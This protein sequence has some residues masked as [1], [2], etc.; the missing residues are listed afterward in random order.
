MKLDSLLSKHDETLHEKG[1]KDSLGDSFLLKN[2]SIFYTVRLRTL[3]LGYK[4]SHNFNPE[5]LALP[6][7]QLESILVSKN[8]P[9]SDNVSAL[10]NI[11]QKT[12]KNLDWDHIVDG[13]KANYVFH[14]SCHAISRNVSDELQINTSEVKNK[15]TTV[16]IEESF[17]NTCEFFL[18]A[19]SQDA[20]HR[21]FLEKNSYFTVFDDRTHLK[22]TIEKYSLAS[23]F[24][25]MLLCYLHSNFLHEQ[26]KDAD[27]KKILSLCSFK[28]A[29][30]NKVLKSLAQN[31]FALNPRFRYTTTEMYLKLNGISGKV[32]DVLNFDCFS[33]IASNTQLKRLISEL[34]LAIARS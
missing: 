24:E 25:F 7:S 15:I 2:N 33:L 17:A 32:T 27:L 5:Y 20:V 23:M 14:E 26:L 4:F 21:L 29:P 19:E 12:H 18:I 16:L 31:A 28:T 3:D 8:I 22:K 11:N 13:L 30:E 10:K 9:Y 34:T 6:M 1:L